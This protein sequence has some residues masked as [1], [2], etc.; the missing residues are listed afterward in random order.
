MPKQLSKN[1]CSLFLVFNHE[2]TP[3]QEADAATTLGV[4]R[5]VSLPKDLQEL[6]SAVP[7]DIDELTPY[8]LPIKSWLLAEA[9]PDD[10]VLVQGDFG[11]TY[12]IVKFALQNGLRPVYSTTER[13]AE[14]IRQPDGSITLV[15]HFRHHRFRLYGR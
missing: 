10:F 15:H 3:V 12:L 4:R 1:V 8:L 13:Q 5:I 9:R 14:E 6:W 11:A 7:P 2:I